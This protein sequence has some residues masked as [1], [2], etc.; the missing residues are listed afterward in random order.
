[1]WIYRS[2]RGPNSP[3]IIQH[4]T[5]P[6]VCPRCSLSL[7]LRVTHGTLGLRGRS[8][9]GICIWRWRDALQLNCNN[10]DDSDG[11]TCSAVGGEHVAADSAD[12]IPIRPLPN[13]QIIYIYTPYKTCFLASNISHLSLPSVLLG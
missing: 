7:P 5:T 3:I 4:Q 2:N 8:V 9:C 1:M 11:N 13:F 10:N 6:L 12:G